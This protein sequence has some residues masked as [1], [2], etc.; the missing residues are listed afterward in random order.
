MIDLYWGCLA[1]GII[2]AVIS[3]IFGDLL[4]D[5]FDGLFDAVSVDGVDFIH[6]MVIVGAITVFGGS[7]IILSQY[8]AMAPL[9]VVVLSLLSA[10]LVSIL[11]YFAYVRP[12]KNSENSTGFSVQDLVGKIGE[13]VTPIPGNGCGEILIRIGAGN[14]NQIA[15][16]LDEE[17]LAVGTRVV[18]AE[19]KDHVLYVFPYEE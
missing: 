9:R 2:F 11:V 17:G 4:G 6:P 15:A 16:S 1:G 18:V 3:L 14:T 5:I 12:M 7:G 19:V 13:V 10:M 8:T